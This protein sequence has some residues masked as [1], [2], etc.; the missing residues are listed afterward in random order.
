[1]CTLWCVHCD[2]YIVMCTM[3]CVQC[4]VYNVMLYVCR[5]CRAV[6]GDNKVLLNS[7]AIVLSYRSQ[8]ERGGWDR[9]RNEQ[10]KVVTDSSGST[11]EIWKEARWYYQDNIINDETW[12]DNGVSAGPAPRQPVSSPALTLPPIHPDWVSLEYQTHMCTGQVLSGA[13]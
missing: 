12:R 2:V 7:A 1:M 10:N 6:W 8:E 13:V 3:W 4:D 5:V 9:A 11:E